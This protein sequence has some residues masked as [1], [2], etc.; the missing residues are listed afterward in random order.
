MSILQNKIENAALR[1]FYPAWVTLRRPAPP[2]GGALDLSKFELV[3]E[4][5]F[6][7]LDL[8][9]W[10]HRRSRNGAPIAVRKGGFWAPEQAFVQ[11]GCL[12]I[13][14][15]HRAD[16]PSGPGY[17]AA[18]LDTSAS[19][20]QTYGYFECRC[21]LPAAQGIWAAFWL[22]SD[23]VKQGVPPS[24]GMEIDVFESPL[25]KRK[26]GNA[27]ITS[28]L[29]YNGYGL[30]HRFQNVGFFMAEEPYNR[31]NTYGVEWNEREYIFYINGRETARSSC[32]GVS[33]GPEYMLLS[34]EVDGTGGSPGY[35]WSGH[36][37]KNPPGALPADF[38]VD[39]VRAYQ[40]KAKQ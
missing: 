30:G 28:N 18:C 17:Y 38:V 25:Y 1:L 39:Y 11:D 14:A 23:A 32:G 22:Q 6:N 20:Q 24:Q 26:A 33:Q 4:D 37:G 29:H 8:Q 19:Y 7:K 13:R 9:T 16:G 3:F 2:K 35:G 5:P 12:H 40:Y 36:V 21:K 15:E 34:V 27:V 10:G 31:F